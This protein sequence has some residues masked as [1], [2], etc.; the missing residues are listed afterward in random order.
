MAAFAIDF[1]VT[2]NSEGTLLTLEDLSNWQSNDEGYIRADF[3]RT[4]IIT[5]SAGQP[6]DTLELPIDSDTITF[7]LDADARLNFL[8]S[9]VGV[10]TFTKLEK[11]TFDRQ[12][13]NKLQTALMQYGCCDSG[14]DIQNINTS[15]SFD[16]GAW[17][18]TP[19]DNDTGVASNLLIA[20]KFIDLVV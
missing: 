1:E 6:V 16:F 20:N 11:Y 4:F 12:Y 14:T 3:V 17:A 10:V 2:S 5:D 8:F 9:I 19:T 7:V 18:I 15:V 13:V